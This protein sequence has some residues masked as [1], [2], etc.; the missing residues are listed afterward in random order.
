[1]ASK[2]SSPDNKKA[3]HSKAEGKFSS[4]QAPNGLCHASSLPSCSPLRL[5]PLL[6]SAIH[7]HV[8]MCVLMHSITDPIAHR[9]CQ[10]RNNL[11][12]PRQVPY[13]VRDCAFVLRIVLTVQAA[14]VKEENGTSDTKPTSNAP[15]GPPPRPTTTGDTPDY[16]NTYV[17]LDNHGM[18]TAVW[19]RLSSQ[20]T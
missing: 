8:V 15:L 13:S 6:Y 11:P 12:G 3:P 16:F 19:S 5:P 20:S 7:R 1:M 4:A 17:V 9:A 14:P 18:P 10:G 2:T